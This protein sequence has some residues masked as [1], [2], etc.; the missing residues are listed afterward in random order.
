MR[1]QALGCM[2]STR[3]SLTK[4]QM[5][6]YRVCQEWHVPIFWLREIPILSTCSHQSSQ[7]LGCRWWNCH[8]LCF[9]SLS[10]E[11]YKREKKGSRWH[12]RRNQQLLLLD[13][14]FNFGTLDNIY[15]T[16]DDQYDEGDTNH[17]YHFCTRLAAMRLARWNGYQPRFGSSF[18]NIYILL[19]WFV[20]D[21]LCPGSKIG[22]HS[23]FISFRLL[24]LIIQEISR[25]GTLLS[26]SL[27]I[28][29]MPCPPRHLR[30]FF[31]YTQF[32]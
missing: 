1:E 2:I 12:I 20:I 29:R 25:N 13:I 5:L 15:A 30:A 21:S 4:V 19:F 17:W 23:R 14:Q 9:G 26:S 11:D 18:K 27:S 28:I 24:I 8:E 22:V 31:K 6:P 16:K 3:P 7:L 10:L 32:G